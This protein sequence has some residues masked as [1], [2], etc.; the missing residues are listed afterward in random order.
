MIEQGKDRFYHPSNEAELAELIQEAR[1][2]G[3]TLRVRG[4][5]HS[6]PAAI[7]TDNFE[8]P[9]ANERGINVM[10]DRMNQI[11]FDDANMQVKVEA[12]CHFGVDPFDPTKTSSRQNAL[13]YQMQERGWALPITGGIIHQT[14]GGFLGTGSSGGSLKHSLNAAIVQLELLDGLGNKRTFRRS[15]N[16][17]DPFFAVGVSLGLLGVITSVIFQCEPT[18]NVGG[19]EITTGYG[20]CAYDLFGEVGSTWPT[21]QDFF[22]HTEYGRCMWWPQRGIRKMVVW[23]ASRLTGEPEKPFPKRYNEF[24]EFPPGSTWLCNMLVGVLMR[25][26]KRLN[27]PPAR[28]VPGTVIDTLL[29]PVF[30][31][32]ANLFLASGAAGSQKFRE[33][34]CDA[35]PMDNRVDYFWTPTEFSEMWVPVEKTQA[36]MRALRDHYERSDLTQVGTYSVEIYGTP[37]SRFWLSPAYQ[38][39]VVKFDMF[40]FGKNHGDPAQVFYPQFWQIMRQFD[41]RFHWGKYMPVDPAYLREQYPRWDDFMALRQELDPHQVF[42]TPYWRERLGIP[43]PDLGKTA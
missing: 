8:T 25:F 26:F 13:V 43:A 1:A 4:S 6:V 16:D 19:K 41:C 20:D 10:L 24:P 35:L 9:S 12:G 42:V 2:R 18:F 32:L 39:D 21:L 36:V 30:T 40:W 29:K 31:C 11:E 3:V 34:W 15:D 37:Q 27:P 33:A 22:L 7:F 38:Q 5:A 23:Q 14:M 17:D 28:T